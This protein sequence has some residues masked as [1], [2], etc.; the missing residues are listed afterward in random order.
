MIILSDNDVRGAMAALRRH[1]EHEWADEST[2]LDLRFV[3]LEDLGLRADS[4]DAEIYSKC[5]SI[6]AIL[7]TAD[8]TTRDGPES[9][10]NIIS[11]LGREDS[12]PVIT[13][14][15][16][17]RLMFDPLYLG[18]C[19]FSMMDCLSRIDELRGTRRIFLPFSLQNPSQ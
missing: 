1:I 16:P 10:E 11:Q 14:G 9:L 12:A 13:I 8:R 7:V 3:Q 4:S 17:E 6:G 15:D 2:N 19:A 5:E 18:E